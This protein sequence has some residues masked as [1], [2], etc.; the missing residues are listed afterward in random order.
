MAV[1]AVAERVYT[2]PLTSS[3][4]GLAHEITDEEFAAGRVLG[5]YVALCGARFCP[6]AGSEPP[7]RAC[8]ACVRQL[9]AARGLVAK[10]VLVTVP[11]QRR[12]HARHRRPGRL[13][14]LLAHVGRTR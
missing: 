7:G 11:E 14:T 9:L 2:T 13:H 10:P 1:I 12:G 4:D 5:E 8:P 3:A 6:N